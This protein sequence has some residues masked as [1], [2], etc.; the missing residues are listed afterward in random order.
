MKK[1][2][3]ILLAATMGL[4]P[5]QAARAEMIGP[6][7]AQSASS[8]PERETLARTLESLGVPRD[9]ARA[10]VAALGDEE[11]ARLAAQAA[12]APA[13]GNPTFLFIA[14]IGVLILILSRSLHG[15]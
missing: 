3:C 4:V 1:T 8:S 5:L 15:K 2:L 14:L 9:E 11:A 12:S 6:D 7:V 13:A 10:R